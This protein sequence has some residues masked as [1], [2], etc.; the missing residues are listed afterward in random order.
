M[1]G[2]TVYEPIALFAATGVPGSDVAR[3]PVPRR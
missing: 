2:I 3:N 1:S